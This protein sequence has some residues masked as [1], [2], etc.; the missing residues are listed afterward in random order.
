MAAARQSVRVY[1]AS[2]GGCVGDEPVLELDI[3][4]LRRL[5]SLD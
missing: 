4:G 3:A 1:G 2:A 5:G